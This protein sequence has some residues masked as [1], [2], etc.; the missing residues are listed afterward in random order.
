MAQSE[1][2]VKKFLDELTDKAKPAA[3]KEWETMQAFAA[4]HLDLKELEKWDT[5][6][7]SEKLKQATLDL[8]EQELKPYFPL[9]NVLKGL[10]D[11][12]GKL[13]EIELLENKEI[14]TYHPDVK[15]YE[16]HKNGLFTP[17]CT[18]TSSH[19][20]ANETVLG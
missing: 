6:F 7:V 14:D 17:C 19:V 8:D 16:V 12:V 3:T 11:I 5:A 2:N 1:V 20:Q 18:L 9:E 13:Y 4:Q 10:F 15:V